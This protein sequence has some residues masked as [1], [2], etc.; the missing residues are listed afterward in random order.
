[1]HQITIPLSPLMYSL[2]HIAALLL[3]KAHT[4]FRFSKFLFCFVFNEYQFSVPGFHRGY[5][6]AYPIAFSHHVL[7]GFFFYCDIVLDFLSLF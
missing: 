2:I 5:R 4:L 1:M 7:L 3:T 6:I